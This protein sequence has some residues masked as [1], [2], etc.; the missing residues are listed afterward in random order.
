MESERVLEIG[1][2]SADAL[3]AAHSE[4]IIHRDIKPSLLARI[5]HAAKLTKT[6]LK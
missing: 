5:S 2:E 1:M 3:D 4:G 6:R